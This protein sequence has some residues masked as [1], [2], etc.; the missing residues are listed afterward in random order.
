MAAASRVSF[1]VL[2]GHA[3]H[4]PQSL[5]KLVT[6]ESNPAPPSWTERLMGLRGRPIRSMKSAWDDIDDPF[7]PDTITPQ[8]DHARREAARAEANRRQDELNA[9]LAAERHERALDE[10]TELEGYGTF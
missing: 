4:R 10:L 8:E 5:V 9:R 7:G 2:Y 3:L 1:D 6:L